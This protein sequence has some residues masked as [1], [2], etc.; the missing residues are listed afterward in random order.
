MGAN[1]VVETPDDVAEPII[2]DGMPTPP[3]PLV[4]TALLT[5]SSFT[6]IT[7][8]INGQYI[9]IGQYNVTLEHARL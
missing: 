5:G 6:F 4:D 3:T 9:T 8:T 2:P 7:V 1:P